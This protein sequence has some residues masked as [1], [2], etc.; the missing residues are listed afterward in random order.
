MEEGGKIGILIVIGILLFTSIFIGGT[1]YYHKLRVN[2]FQITIKDLSN[3]QKC[4]HICGFE[5]ESQFESY[6][7]CAEK[8]NKIF[9]KEQKCPSTMDTLNTDYVQ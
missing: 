6:N 2:N 8:C 3:E 1:Y 9:E 7:F 4:L 5:F